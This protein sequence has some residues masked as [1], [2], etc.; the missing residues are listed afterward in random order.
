MKTLSLK[1]DS[2]SQMLDISSQINALIPENFSSGFCHVFCPHTT[3]GLA[4]NENA[5]PDVRSD[6]LKTLDKLVPWDD[7]SYRHA[8]GNSA[9][10]LKAILTGASQTIPVENGR[11]AL[12]TWQGLYFCEFDGPRT[13]T[14]SVRFFKDILT[15]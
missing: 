4:I 6:I 15:E 8:E 5:D 3:A 11:L 1:T 2:R 9:A 10:H 12:G 13:R 14:I 7:G